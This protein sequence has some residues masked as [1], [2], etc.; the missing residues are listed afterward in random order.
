MTWPGL[1]HGTS[2]FLTTSPVVD[3]SHGMRVTGSAAIRHRSPLLY[4][5]GIFPVSRFKYNVINSLVV[6]EDDKQHKTT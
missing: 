5:D 1:E 3:K 2:H 6:C 4:S